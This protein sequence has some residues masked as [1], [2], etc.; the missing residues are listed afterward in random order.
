M[1]EVV[2]YILLGLLLAGAA[3]SVAPSGSISTDPVPCSPTHRC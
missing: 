2:L 1:K 3:A